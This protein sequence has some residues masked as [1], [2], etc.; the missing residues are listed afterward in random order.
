MKTITEVIVI[1]ILLFA[2]IGSACFFTNNDVA[3]DGELYEQT[4]L[5]T[6][7]TDYAYNV[8]PIVPSQPACDCHCSCHGETVCPEN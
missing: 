8:Q 6:L 3:T 7:K 2:F 4:R 5:E 1:L